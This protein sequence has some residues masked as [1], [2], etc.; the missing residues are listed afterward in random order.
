MAWDITH[1]ANDPDEVD[2]QRQQR[3]VNQATADA[4]RILAVVSHQPGNIAVV[5]KGRQAE[6]YD[7]PQ[8]A[9][10]MAVCRLAV[11]QVNGF[12]VPQQAAKNH[13]EGNH[14]RPEENQRHAADHCGSQ[15]DK[16]RHQQRKQSPATRADIAISNWLRLR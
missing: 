2:S 16:Q 14:L 3:A 8:I 9:Q 15:P 11:E 12:D 1:G 13:Q 10:V 7:C 6:R 5:A 4:R